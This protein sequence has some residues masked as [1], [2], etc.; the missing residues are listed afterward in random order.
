MILISHRGNINGAIPEMENHPD[1]IKKA[2]A[3]G[4][5]VEVDVW[6]IKD[7]FYLGHDNPQYRIDK[8]FL[9]TDGLW[10]HCK[11]VEALEQLK[12]YRTVN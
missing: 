11:N 8:I 3:E 9:Q 10:I 4:Y 12:F 7:A 6:Y 1:Y 2:L 5:D